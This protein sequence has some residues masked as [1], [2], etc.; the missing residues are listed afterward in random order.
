MLRSAEAEHEKSSPANTDRITRISC[1]FRCRLVILTPNASESHLRS[2]SDC[3]VQV[4]LPARQ[5][6]KANTSTSGQKVALGIL[7]LHHWLRSL[8]R[9]LDFG[10]PPPP[11]G[12]V[13][14]LQRSALLGNLRRLSKPM[15]SRIQVALRFAPAARTKHCPSGETARP[16]A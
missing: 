15:S 7:S 16:S 14:M 11:E 9:P 10:G 5:V 13:E 3:E 8:R 6:I 2:V 4:E 12:D 1:C